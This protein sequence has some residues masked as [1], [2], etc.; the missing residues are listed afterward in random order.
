MKLLL[1]T[2]LGLHELLD[3]LFVSVDLVGDVVN[4]SYKL[5]LGLLLLL[6]KG[7]DH[8]VELDL[9]LLHLKFHLL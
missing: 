1:L 9:S 7:Q 3:F 2:F 8:H 6:P 4:V 5:N